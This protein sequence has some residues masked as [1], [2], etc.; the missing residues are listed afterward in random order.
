MFFLLA[1]SDPGLR[2][3]LTESTTILVY[4]TNTKY[5]DQCESFCR[6]P[7]KIAIASE[8]SKCVYKHHENMP[9]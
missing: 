2:F 1:Q 9:I 3:A 6:N 4:A 5:P 8:S 7:T